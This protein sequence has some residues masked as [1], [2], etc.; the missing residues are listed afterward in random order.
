MAVVLLQLY[1]K[2][3]QLSANNQLSYLQKYEYN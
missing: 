2:N 1:Q 3:Q